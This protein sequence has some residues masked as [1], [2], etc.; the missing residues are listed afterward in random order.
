MHENYQRISLSNTSALLDFIV[1]SFGLLYRTIIQQI[2]FDSSI[3][4]VQFLANPLSTEKLR[5][6]MEDF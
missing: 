3:L 6:A 4:L 5:G 2:M 1:I